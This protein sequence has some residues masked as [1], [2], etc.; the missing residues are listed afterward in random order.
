[1]LEGLLLSS[2]TELAV[3]TDAVDITF[4]VSCF[5]EAE[6][7]GKALD[8]IQEAMAAHSASYEIL[9]VDDG[10]TDRT[11]YVVQA[12]HA[13][14]PHLPIRLHRHLSN[15]G[16][17]FSYFEGASL[18]KGRYYMLVAGDGDLPSETILN[19]VKRMGEA[20][21]INPY[22]ADQRARPFIRR[23]FSRTFTKLVSLLGGHSLHYYNGPVLHRRI[24]ILEAKS[25]PNGFG[26]QA[27]LLCALL[28]EGRSVIEIP[29]APSYRHHQTDA[30]HLSNITSVLRSLFR[31]FLSR[32]RR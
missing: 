30:F 5:N 15:R 29:F 20:D 22:F 16:L 14:H 13:A 4:F 10:S 24:N 18:A 31:I 26:Y 17:G 11:H 6:N 28:R 3:A 19:I 7:V 8:A 23:I 1:M 2:K 9:V 32:L 12:Y 25:R 21:I 27:E